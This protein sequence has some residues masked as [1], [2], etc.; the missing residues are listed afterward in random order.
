MQ[1]GNDFWNAAF[2]CGS[3]AVIRRSALE[4]IGGFAIA[5][6]DRGRAY[7]AQHAPEWLAI[8]LPEAAAGCRTGD[9]AAVHACRPADALGARHG[10]DL[11]AR[12][13]DARPGPQHRPAPLLPERHGAF[14]LRAA[15]RGVP[16][17]AAG[18]AVVQPEHHRRVAVRDHC[19]RPAASFPLGRRPTHASCGIGGIRSGA[20]ST[21]RCWRCFWCVSPS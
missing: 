12:Q 6:R 18:L 21:K 8:G 9:R 20:R 2:F 7:R 15:A 19:L 14:F 5:D 13:S 4:W 3:C 11:P 10:A 1:D 17:G 16:D